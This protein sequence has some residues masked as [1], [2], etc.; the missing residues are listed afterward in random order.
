MQLVGACNSVSD[1]T[2]GGR[3]RS[4]QSVSAPAPAAVAHHLQVDENRIS[5]SGYLCRSRVSKSDPG[6]VATVPRTNE[7]SGTGFYDGC[8]CDRHRR[9]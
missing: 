1:E 2:G 8:G 7:V 5:S 3:S 4:G 6:A 9:R